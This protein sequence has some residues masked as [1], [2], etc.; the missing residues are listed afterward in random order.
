VGIVH[1][2]DDFSD[3][4]RKDGKRGKKSF[5]VFPIFRFHLGCICRL[6][7]VG[8]AAAKGLAALPILSRPLKW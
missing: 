8:T 6:A 2:R 1:V 5:P 3:L 7:A 4:S